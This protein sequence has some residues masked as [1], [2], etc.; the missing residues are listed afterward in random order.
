LLR[1]RALNGDAS[2]SIYLVHPL[3]FYFVYIKLQPPLPPLRMQ[4]PLRYGVDRRAI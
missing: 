2:Y 3:V 4:E 1:I